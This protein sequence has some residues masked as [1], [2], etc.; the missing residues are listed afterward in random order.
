MIVS[1][2]ITADILNRWHQ[3]CLSEAV[4][5]TFLLL[6]SYNLCATKIIRLNST[7]Y[8]F[9]KMPYKREV[10]Q[11]AID[12]SSYIKKLMSLCKKCKKAAKISALPSGRIDKYEY[13]MVKEILSTGQS[14]II[15]QVK[16][17]FYL[18]GKALKN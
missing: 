5:Q 3:N 11:I 1:D 9:M 14:R 7:H 12:H 16:F 6:L 15:K 13:L 10:Q 8:C 17:T 2:D 4:K 18:L